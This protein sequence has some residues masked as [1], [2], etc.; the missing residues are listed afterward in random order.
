M[1]YNYYDNF[2]VGASNYGFQPNNLNNS[3]YQQTNGHHND[4]IYHQQADSSQHSGRNYHPHPEPAT[5]IRRNKKNMLIQA[6]RPIP[7]VHDENGYY[8]SNQQPSMAMMLVESSP[9]SPSSNSQEGGRGYSGVTTKR[10]HSKKHQGTDRNRNHSKAENASGD[11]KS[12]SRAIQK[13]VK[14]MAG[15]PSAQN[16]ADEEYL[17]TKKVTIQPYLVF[18]YV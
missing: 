2:S 16:A 3:F 17:T 4:R 12:S 18:L 15:A 10:L 1:A 5:V 11:D 13:R 7:I 6:H 8:P 9:S 14:G